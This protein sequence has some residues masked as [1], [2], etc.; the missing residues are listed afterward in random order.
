MAREPG[1]SDD[2]LSGERKARAVRVMFD[3][4]APRY[5]RMNRLLTLGMD[6]RW[7]RRTVEALD[8][9]RGSLVMDLACGTGDL[10]RELARAGHRPVGFD[11]ALGMLRAART[12]APLA[13]ADVLRMPVADGSADG[14]TCGFALRNVADLE[15]L[16]A[17]IARVV[18]PGGRIA[19]LEV[20]EPL[21][22]AAG[23]PDLLGFHDPDGGFF[24]EHGATGVVGVGAAATIVVPAG[25]NQVERAADRAE[26]ALRAFHTDPGPGP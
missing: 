22:G 9:S 12:G 20:S 17:E 6:V 26:E 16:F 8:L 10:C 11:F 18:R 25:P 1:V 7:R 4:V 13:Q 15:A 19:L 23:P 5:D 14:V 2:L 24:F 21:D 3:R